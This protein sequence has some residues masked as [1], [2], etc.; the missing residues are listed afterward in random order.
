MDQSDVESE[1]SLTIDDD[2]I[3]DSGSVCDETSPFGLFTEDVFVQIEEGSLEH[4]MIMRSFLTGMGSVAKYTNVVAIHKN[5]LSSLT[6]KARLESFQ[7][8][9]EAVAEKCGGNA[10]VRLGWFGGPREEILG[11]V[12]H[13]FSHC[14]RRPVNGQSYGV[15]VHLASTQFS[16]DGALSSDVDEDGLKHILLCRVIMGNM[17]VIC[18]GSNQFHP[19]SQNFDSG[20]DNLLA[21]RRYIVWSANMNSHIFPTFVISF[22]VP[23]ENDF[24]SVQANV[25]K[26]RTSLMTFSALISILSRFLNPSKMALIDKCYNDFRGHKITRPQF[27]NWLRLTAGDGLL[28]EVLKRYT[29]ERSKMRQNAN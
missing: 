25:P 2:E 20:V 22:K 15:G 26:P 27:I 23:S 21:P 29:Q 5:S 17:E 12:K 10:N 19:S 8:F 28:L 18:P 6:R 14:G 24:L 9:S 1:I 7:L 4:G 13:G 3:S 11:I 16:I